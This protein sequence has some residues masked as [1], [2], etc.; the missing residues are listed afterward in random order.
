MDIETV[1]VSVITAFGISG[2]IGYFVQNYLAQKR[3]TE[4]RIQEDN[5]GHY[6]SWMVWMRMVMKP[7]NINHF[8]THDP[9][10]PKLTNAEDIR[11][12]AKDRL[13]EF[14]YSAI[15]FC[16]DYV[17]AAMKEFLINSNETNFMKVAV[18]MR[19][20]LWRK[21]TKIDLETLSLE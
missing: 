14:Y 21:N 20:D 10:I 3:Q 12:F 11:K 8:N 2:V 16:P 4:L 18:A 9:T 5:R 1:L 17:L 13:I 19:K 15:F 6:E 7:E